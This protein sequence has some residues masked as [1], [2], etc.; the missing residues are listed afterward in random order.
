MP[1][2]ILVVVEQR[3]GEIKTQSLQTL[4]KA[5]SLVGAMGGDLS[6]AIIGSGID[7]LVDVVKPYG[8]AKVYLADAGHLADY[9]NASYADAAAAAAAARCR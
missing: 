2:G 7:G 1:A 4:S 6:V 9:R 3:E 5:A 8:P